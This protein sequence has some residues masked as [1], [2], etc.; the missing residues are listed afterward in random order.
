MPLTKVSCDMLKDECVTALRDSFAF[1]FDDD[2]A[3]DSFFSANLNLLENDG[4]VST[5]AFVGTTALKYAFW[6]GLDKP[7]IYD[8]GGWVEIPVVATTT[9]DIH[10]W[11]DPTVD[12]SMRARRDPATGFLH[13]ERRVGGVWLDKLTISNSITV[14]SAK[15]IET[16]FMPTVLPGDLGLYG[17]KLRDSESGNAY[18]IRPVFMDSDHK[19]YMVVAGMPDGSLRVPTN[20][21]QALVDPENVPLQYHHV[22]FDDQPDEIA[23][24][25]RGKISYND[26]ADKPTIPA[27]VTWSKVVQVSDEDISGAKLD[28]S[29][30]KN[31]P[32]SGPMTGTEIIQAIENDPSEPHLPAALVSDLTKT[33]YRETD[34]QLLF[35]PIDLTFM[36]IVFEHTNPTTQAMP[37]IINCRDGFMLMLRNSK[38]DES[39]VTLVPSNSGQTVNGAPSYDMDAGVS[40]LFVCMKDRLDWHL[41]A[42]FEHDNGPSIAGVTFANDVADA[43]GVTRINVPTSEIIAKGTGIIDL[44]PYITLRNTPSS[45]S[46]VVAKEIHF[47]PPLKTFPSPDA[48]EIGRVYVDPRAYETQHAASCLLQL[49]NDV[50]L[51]TGHASKLY[52]AHEVVPTGEYYSLNPQ[53]G[54]VN[55][56]DN[57]GGDTAATG[58]ELTRIM[59]S[60]AFYG[61]ATADCSVKL[62]FW[63]K[64]PASVLPGGI[65]HD[66]NNHPMVVERR[67]NQGDDLAEPLIV[68]GAMMATG[69]SPV[70]MYV[71]TSGGDFV[72][73]PDQTLVCIEQ[74]SDGYEVSLSSVEFQRRLGVEIHAEIKQFTGKMLSM[75]DELLGVAQPLSV[76][77]PDQG[78]DFLNEF[79]I[80]N[81]TEV[82][83]SIENDAL[84]ISD[85]G[86]IADFYVDVYIDNIKT[87]MLRGREISYAATVANPRD[88]YALEVYK[89]TGRADQAGKVY[90]SRNNDSL[91]LN[92]GFVLVKSKAIPEQPDG[93]YRG[94]ADTASIPDDANNI[95]IVIR[96]M[97]AQMPIALSVKDFSWGSAGDFRGYVE[98]SR[99]N[100]REQHLWFSESW[101]EFGLNSQ[102]FALLRYTINNTPSEGNPMP[103]GVLLKG[104]APVEI[105]NSVNQVSGSGDPQNDGAIKFT[106][107]GEAAISKSYNTWNEQ[108]TDN[109]VTFWDVLIDADGSESKIPDSEKTFTIPKHT[110]APGIVYTVPAYKIE[111]EAG[112]RIGGRATSNVADGAYVQSQN[113]SEYIVMT[114]IDFEELVPGSSDDP[115]LIIGTWE[116]KLVTDFIVVP[117]AGIIAQNYTFD[118]DIPADVVITSVIV[119]DSSGMGESSVEYHRDDANSQLTVNIGTITDGHIYITFRG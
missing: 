16:Q 49:D 12:G 68:T 8:A 43:A 118:I 108:G 24:L 117:F 84:N 34:D 52:P 15:F 42:E 90:S 100:L 81:L 82:Q 98:T 45:Q 73:N 28:A 97:V 55:V 14:D 91:V 25:L 87:R 115:Q 106:K 113:A 64:D 102:G 111:V 47:Q 76:V 31:L 40:S 22:L 23:A 119:E 35:S 75:K 19:H 57:T 71:E 93:Q 44:I 13:F 59:G 95:F 37:N 48:Q 104:K 70:V 89:W 80:Q 103:V 72:V 29:H 46:D 61:K 36:E 56:Q 53:A 60:V 77:P 83:M 5:L 32:D 109:T 7:S 39:V 33:D 1:T 86:N 20:P 92:E 69:I 105:D 74:F 116:R 66:V 3:R 50:T 21:E 65:L 62:W 88:A 6:N 4:L 27:E 58:G 110:G 101:A 67:Y 114:T 78:Y 10:Y 94:Y 18:V 38:T 99:V 2:T 63:Y 30:I 11:G 107:D 26:I 96:P 51:R 112:Q 9:G 85:N 41:V 54:G 79:G 17:A